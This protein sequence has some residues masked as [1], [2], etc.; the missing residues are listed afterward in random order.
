MRNAGSTK[1]SAPASWPTDEAPACHSSPELPPTKHPANTHATNAPTP[2]AT[3][4]ARKPIAYVFFTQGFT[5]RVD[6][7]DEDYDP[8][9]DPDN[10]LDDDVEEIPRTIRTAEQRGSGRHTGVIAK[11]KNDNAKEADKEVDVNARRK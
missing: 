2:N 1:S 6:Y 3:L 10:G 7:N 5:M 4:R 11:D 8:E 9:R